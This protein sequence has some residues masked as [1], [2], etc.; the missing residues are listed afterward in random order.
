MLKKLYIKNYAIIDELNISFDEELNVITGETGAGKS[1]I[2]G[3]I[4]LI[5]GER[6][7]TSVLI[8]REEKCIVEAHFDTATQD[9]FNAL[10]LREELDEAPITIIRREIST[11]GKSRAFIND[12]PVTLNILNELTSTL[13][14]LH[15]QFDNRALEHRA[16]LYDV[17]DAIGD[18]QTLVS[19]YKR[20]FDAY[21]QLKA[22]FKKLSEQ[23]AS[24]QKESDYKQFL[25]DE[26]EQYAA[27]PD[28]IEQS[29][30]T[31]KQL[32]HA[33]QIINVL[34]MVHFSLED[35]EHP[36]NNELKRLV[37]ALQG[38]S[39]IQPEAHTLAQRMESALLEL[40]DIAQEVSYLQ[41]KVNLDPEQLQ[42]LQERVDT[43][44]RLLKKHGVTSTA[45]LLAIHEQLAQELLN[46]NNA[47][48]EL[49]ELNG[50]ILAAEKELQHLSAAIST[51]R[52]AAIIPFTRQINDLLHLVGMPNAVLKIDLQ[53]SEY[54]HE[55]GKDEIN[56][57]LDANKSGK[58]AAVQKAA[59]GGELSRIMLCIKTLI[60][61]A[62]AL[63]TLIFD[64]VDA[65]ISGEAARQ[66][67]ILL[68]DLSSY[69]QVLCITHQ[70]QVAGKG[71][72]HFY[73]FKNI[74]ESGKVK[75]GIRILN[76]DERIRAIA[77]MIGGADPS[78]AAIENARELV[79]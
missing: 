22:S 76:Q 21:H 56:F 46:H 9:A 24:W 17:V 52:E 33:E 29:E 18:N 32:S 37:Q 1:I 25:F 36:L 39:G 54:F 69:H 14:D 51:A 34:Q 43:G 70:P 6:A 20:S 65:G 3:A 57:L 55:F 44:Y 42:Y 63:P 45:S 27:K 68:R 66:V 2:L 64:E 47:E 77:Q 13:V 67:G 48:S 19:Q 60:A 28:E 5:L 74:S 11:S 53:P 26:L 75:T 58:F 38:I 16:F 71:T 50:K 23:H 31:L 4:S 41:D 30:T 61:K 35:G 12:T 10:L 7:D 49:E 79:S 15:R 8:N 59:S 40:R 62:L 73:V 78:E 72:Q